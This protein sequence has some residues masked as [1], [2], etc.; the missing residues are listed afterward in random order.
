MKVLLR[1]MSLKDIKHGG[2]MYGYTIQKINGKRIGD[3]DRNNLPTV[4]IVV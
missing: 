4:N 2:N 3:I 1:R